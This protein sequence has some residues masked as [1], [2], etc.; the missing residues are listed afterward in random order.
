MIKNYSLEH[1]ENN[2]K[3]NMK[4]YEC[5]MYFEMI[6]YFFFFLFFGCLF[7]FIN[8]I[9][10][11]RCWIIFIFSINHLI[12]I[13]M[14]HISEQVMKIKYLG[15]FNNIKVVRIIQTMI[16]NITITLKNI[17][18]YIHRIK[19]GNESIVMLIIIYSI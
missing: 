15:I 3:V 5:Y 1:R 8:L 17:Q 10:L 18:H 13:N 4:Y 11:I 19:F 16:N 12:Y 6:N 2:Q 14:I 7:G 9:F